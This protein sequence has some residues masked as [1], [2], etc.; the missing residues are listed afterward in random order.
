[1]T[2]APQDYIGSYRLLNLIRTGKTC[3]LWEAMHDAKGQKFALKVL[4]GEY[5]KDRDEVHYLRHEYAVG[6]ALKHPKVIKIQELVVDRGNVYLAMEYCPAPNLKQVI[7]QGVEPLLPKMSSIVE[8]AAEGLAY[9][10]THGWVHRDIKP[11]NF[12]YTSDGIVKLI[13]FALAVRV[14]SGLMKLIPA[15]KSPVQ[16]TR[17]YMAPEQIR[18]L[19]L[20]QRADIYSFGCMLYEL[21]SGKLPFTGSSTND[22]L[23]KHLKAA[24]PSLQAANRNVSDQFA[25]LV[26]KTMAK[27]PQSR[28]KTVT[29]FLNEFRGMKIFKEPPQPAKV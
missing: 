11:D 26:K 29:D 16:G 15:R 17:S 3:Q 21:V 7:Q 14:R 23:M 27:Q 19:A 1:V 2:R 13:D 24:P 18:G 22:L 20:D 28:P 5:V 8:Q 9:F 10:H 25:N 4:L 12:L 6:H